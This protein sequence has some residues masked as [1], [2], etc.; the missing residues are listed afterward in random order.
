MHVLGTPPAFVLSQDQTLHRDR[1]HTP[2][3]VSQIREPAGGVYP[4]PT[5][6]GQTNVRTVLN[7][8][9]GVSRHH[10]RPATRTPALALIVFSSVFKEHRDSRRSSFHGSR[11]FRRWCRCHNCGVPHLQRRALRSEAERYPTGAFGPAQT[12]SEVA[13]QRVT[14]VPA[15]PETSTWTLYKIAESSWQASCGSRIGR[16]LGPTTR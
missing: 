9:T 5:G 4:R 12:G 11:R 8:L 15:V 7:K 2:R 13:E 3:S 1:G 6:T 16:Q 10:N 14:N